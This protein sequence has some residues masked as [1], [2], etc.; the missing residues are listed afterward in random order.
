MDYA[1]TLFLVVLGLMLLGMSSQTVFITPIR[2]AVV[3]IGNIKLDPG[4]TVVSIQTVFGRVGLWDR[5]M[6]MVGHTMTTRTVSGGASTSRVRYY[7]LNAQM[8][9]GSFL[10][11]FIEHAQ[12]SSGS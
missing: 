5:K 11:E 10:D 6:T 9:Q 12:E 1:D 2:K 8:T 3:G 7:W 4:E